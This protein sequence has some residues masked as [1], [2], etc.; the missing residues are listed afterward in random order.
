MVG[1]DLELVV[2]GNGHILHFPD[3]TGDVG[4]IQIGVPGSFADGA[5]EGPHGGLCRRR[6]Y[7]TATFGEVCHT[8]GRIE[9]YGVDAQ[10]G[11]HVATALGHHDGLVESEFTAAQVVVAPGIVT[12]ELELVALQREIHHGPDFGIV[13]NLLQIGIGIPFAGLGRTDE[14]PGLGT[15]HGLQILELGEVDVGQLIVYA[16]DNHFLGSRGELHLVVTGGQ[17]DV[18]TGLGSREGGTHLRREAVGLGTIGVFVGPGEVVADLEATVDVNQLAGV[19]AIFFGQFKVGVPTGTVDV[20]DEGEHV[21]RDEG[22]G[23]SLCIGK[24]QGHVV[25]TGR[26]AEVLAAGGQF[27]GFSQ[28]DGYGFGIAGGAVVLVPGKVLA[29]LEGAVAAVFLVSVGEVGGPDAVVFGHQNVVSPTIEVTH[30]APALLFGNGLFFGQNNVAHASAAG[31]GYIGSFGF[32]VQEK[33]EVAFRFHLDVITILGNGEIIAQAAEVTTVVFGPVGI[34]TELEFVGLVQGNIEGQMVTIT[35]GHHGDISIPA[36]V[37]QLQATDDTPGTDLG[38]VRVRVEGLGNPSFLGFIVEVD[39]EHT[40][41]VNL[42]VI[43]I[44]GDVKLGIQA[45]EITAEVFGPIQI[46]TELELVALGQV[47][48][49]S[50]VVVVAVGPHGQVFVPAHLISSDAADDGPGTKFLILL[51]RA[52]LRQ[53]HQHVL[54]GH[55]FQGLYVTVETVVLGLLLKGSAQGNLHLL[56]HVSVHIAQRCQAAAQRLDGCR[57]HIAFHRGGKHAGCFLVIGLEQYQGVVHGHLFIERHAQRTGSERNE[58]IAVFVRHEVVDDGGCSLTDVV[59]GLLLP[60]AGY[61]GN[62][63]HNCQNI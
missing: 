45:G 51:V 43:A 57:N 25:H 6:R 37:I 32:G 1:A 20:T 39:V 63:R 4:H 61:G 56:H 49:G 12:A 30:D 59:S 19:N 62:T 55:A 15:G 2:C 23:R 34:L 58:H 47:D 35:V 21:G 54:K 31:L 24:I 40:V 7:V 60:H 9:V 18:L 52:V 17:F 14:A 29:E 42:D 53:D 44:L 50:Y 11:R 16:G 38:E 10:Y 22:G 41:G 46:F 33:V 28:F 5:D 13:L 36:D 27:H 48:V 26:S 3:V 8:V